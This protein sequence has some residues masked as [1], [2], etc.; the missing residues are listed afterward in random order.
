MHDAINIKNNINNG[1]DVE[2]IFCALPYYTLIYISVS[3]PYKYKC[4]Q[5]IGYKYKCLQHNV[6]IIIQLYRHVQIYQF[7]NQ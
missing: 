5:H 6:I 3:I 4:F 1:M 2:D 7:V